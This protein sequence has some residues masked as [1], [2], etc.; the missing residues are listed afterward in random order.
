LIEKSLTGFVE[1]IGTLPGKWILTSFIFINGSQFIQ[2]QLP[3]HPE[4]MEIRSDDGTYAQRAAVLQQNREMAE[5]WMNKDTTTPQVV[6]RRR[7]SSI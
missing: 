1:N 2:P 7:L 5:E 3:Q 6:M 4:K